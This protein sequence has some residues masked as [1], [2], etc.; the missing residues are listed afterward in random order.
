MQGNHTK[1]AKKYQYQEIE[2]SKFGYKTEGNNEFILVLLGNHASWETMEV[3][4]DWMELGL[5]NLT[6]EML[7]DFGG[8]A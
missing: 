4:R 1:A 5:P 6:W 3:R 2:Q 7:K 8:G